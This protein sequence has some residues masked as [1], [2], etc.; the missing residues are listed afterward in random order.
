MDSKKP[1]WSDFMR[2][3]KEVS[4]LP[5]VWIHCFPWAEATPMDMFF[6]APPRPAMGWPLKWESISME[7]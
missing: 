6:S 2:A 3:S 1:T 7:S 4:P 5:E